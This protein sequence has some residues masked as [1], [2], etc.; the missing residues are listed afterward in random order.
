MLHITFTFTN[1]GFHICILRKTNCVELIGFSCIVICFFIVIKEDMENL[2]FSKNSTLS[3][4]VVLRILW[5]ERKSEG[6]EDYNKMSWVSLGSSPKLLSVENK[7]A[8]RNYS[9]LYLIETQFEEPWL[10]REFQKFGRNES[11]YA[12]PQNYR[13]EGINLWK[14]QLG[15][16]GL[17][18]IQYS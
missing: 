1:K 5:M 9:P 2:C 17:R 8:K 12:F 10:I 15:T 18:W 7:C 11:T 14:H 3:N 6:F 16:W 13:F 4:S